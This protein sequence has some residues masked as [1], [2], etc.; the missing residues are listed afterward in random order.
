[1]KKISAVVIVIFAIGISVFLLN[2]YKQAAPSKYFYLFIT[3]ASGFIV[4]EIF[5]YKLIREWFADNPLII[6]LFDLFSF[7]VLGFFLYL[8]SILIYPAK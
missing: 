3:F 2:L 6:K 7:V 8:F 4:A 5:L 1:M